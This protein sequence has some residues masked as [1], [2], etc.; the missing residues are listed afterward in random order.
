MKAGIVSQQESLARQIEELNGH[1]KELNG[2]LEE[3]GTR[4][5]ELGENFVDE[6]IDKRY[7]NPS[8]ADLSVVQNDL[9]EAKLGFIKEP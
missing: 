2:Q 9:N 5:I 4:E 3:I 6:T 8:D 7:E 1:I